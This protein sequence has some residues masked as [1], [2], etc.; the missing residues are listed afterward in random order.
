MGRVSVV[1][2]G[3]SAIITVVAVGDAGVMLLVQL[4]ILHRLHYDTPVYLDEVLTEFYDGADKSQDIC[5]CHGRSLDN[6]PHR[7]RYVFSRIF[8]TFSVVLCI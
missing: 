5:C 7:T 6:H 8:P 2:V 3:D 1:A 4:F